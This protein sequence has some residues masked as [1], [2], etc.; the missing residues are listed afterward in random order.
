MAATTVPGVAWGTTV[1]PTFTK[2]ALQTP[3]ASHRSRQVQPETSTRPFQAAGR[4]F[5]RSTSFDEPSR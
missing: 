3:L 1:S 2:G 5:S 4:R